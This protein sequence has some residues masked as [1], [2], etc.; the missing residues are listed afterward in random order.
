MNSWKNIP[1]TVNDPVDQSH[2][3]HNAPVLF[4]TMHHFVTEMCTCQGW[5]QVLSEV[6]ESST[7]TFKY[8]KNKYS[9][10]L[11]GIKYF[12]NQVQVPSTVVTNNSTVS[13][14][15]PKLINNH[16]PGTYSYI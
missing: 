1:L 16:Y 6:L 14:L 11:G 2:K 9:Q 8:F 12:F 4:P 13:L 10:Y 15:S 3:S 5:G 7:S